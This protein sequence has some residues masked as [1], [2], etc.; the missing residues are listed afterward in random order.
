[1]TR[2]RPRAVANPVVRF[3]PSIQFYECDM[4]YLI[5]LLA[6]LFGI[7]HGINAI[8]FFF[9]AL[10]LWFSIAV[11]IWLARGLILYPR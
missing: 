2:N 3:G 11:C 8:T 7:V 10:F 6:L 5:F 9:S 4:K 1:M